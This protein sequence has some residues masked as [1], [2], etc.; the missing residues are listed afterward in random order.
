MARRKLHL[1]M[2]V[3]EAAKQ[4]LRHAALS[5]DTLVA[6]FS[7]GKDS[8]VCL[9]LMHELM[10]EEGLGRK[11]H[12]T[13]WDEEVI[14][15]DVVNFMLMMKQ[16]PWLDLRWLAYPMIGEKFIM[17][18]REDYVSFDPGRPWVRKPPDFAELPPAGA[19]PWYDRVTLNNE[20]VKPYPGKVGFVTGIRAAESMARYRSVVEKLNEN[21]IC[22]AG[23]DASQK[24]RLVKPI[25]DWQIPDI[26]KFL[27]DRGIPWCPWYDKQNIAIGG[28]CRVDTPLHAQS[29]KRLDILKALD[30]DFYRRIMEVFPEMGLQARYYRDFDR[31]GLREKYGTSW[32]GCE[33]FIEKYILDP[34]VKK[35]AYKRVASMKGLAKRDPSRYTTEQLF[36]VLMSGNLERTPIP[37]APKAGAP[38]LAEAT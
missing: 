6:S 28:G 14:P 3:V 18:R 2:D 17:G 38:A 10:E 30:P 36:T 26:F 24:Y 27:L 22:S 20:A 13:F 12:A 33:A 34:D 4:R 31:K 15:D 8:L 19:P 11:V 16:K 32:A 7:G 21:Y 29:S 1:A 9:T 5:F 37:P 35:D 25:Y 23:P